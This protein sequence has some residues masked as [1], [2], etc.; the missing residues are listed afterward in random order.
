MKFSITNILTCLLISACTF[1]QN[2][3]ITINSKVLNAV[4]SR[5]FGQFLEKCSWGGEVGGDLVINPGTGK[6]DSAILGKLK[7][8]DI[9][10]IRYPGGTDVDYYPWT[11]LIDHAPGQ[12]ERKPYRA[13]RFD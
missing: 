4:D 12:N 10:V 8:M 6:P 3:E 1:A 2:P 13:I 7:A 5:L 11:D 9:P